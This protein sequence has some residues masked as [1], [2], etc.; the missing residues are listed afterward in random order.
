MEKLSNSVNLG[1]VEI[2][3]FLLV[4]KYVVDRTQSNITAPLLSLLAFTAVSSQ[5]QENIC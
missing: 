2:L 4:T 3:N 1:D 5:G